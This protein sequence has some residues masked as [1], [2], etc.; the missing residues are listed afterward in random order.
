MGIAKLL[1]PLLTTIVMTGL[2]IP[3][4]SADN[5]PVSGHFLDLP[6]LLENRAEVSSSALLAE[7]QAPRLE[8]RTTFEAYHVSS[9][10][11]LSKQGEPDGFIVLV[12]QDDG[13]FTALVSTSSRRGVVL[14]KAD[15]SQTFQEEI[16]FDGQKDDFVTDPQ[17]EQAHRQRLNDTTTSADSNQEH[18]LTVL[19]GFSE[20]AARQV[21]DPRSFALAQIETLNL[22][23]RNSGITNIRVAL[24]GISTTPTDYVINNVNLNKLKDAF[25]NYPNADLIAGFFASAPQGNVAGIAD[26]YGTY[27]MAHISTTD[28]FAHEI[29]HNIGGAHCSPGDGNYEYGYSTGKYGSLLCRQGTRVLSFSNPNKN[30]PDGKPLGNAQHADMARTWNSNT[31]SK[32]KGLGN[33]SGKAVLLHSLADT[34]QCVDVLGGGNLVP[35][36]QVGLWRCDPN[37][38]NQRWN[39]LYFN[40]TV[41]FWLEARPKLCLYATPPGS[42]RKVVLHETGC[43]HITWTEENH[44]LKTLG[45]G[46][47]LYLHRSDANQLSARIGTPDYSRPAF[48]WSSGSPYSRIVNKH[49]NFCLDVKN[50]QSVAGTHIVFNQCVNN[51]PSQRWLW[52]AS[53]RVRNGANLSF[54]L[55]RTGSGN[56]RTTVLLSCSAN[57]SEVTWS[58]SRNE[59]ITTTEYSHWACLYSSQSPIPGS[60]VPLSTCNVVSLKDWL[61]QPDP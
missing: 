39:K 44:S 25:P 56:N 52:E 14:G 3:A 60:R 30:A 35:G 10:V 58:R 54:C 45:N 26:R 12:N 9:S 41:Q 57:D 33:D 40:N 17:D 4:Y 27:S 5:A 50:G 2:H 28:T 16:A 22:A 36:A 47:D 31:P 59:W 29:G 11:L 15:G 51:T 49:N 34:S 8:P 42:N 48:L 19:V 43:Q 32:A 18:V 24:S 23:L 21:G 55:G 7:M 20:A 37:N 38:P 61:I 1:R 46:E 53:G 6:S 13:S